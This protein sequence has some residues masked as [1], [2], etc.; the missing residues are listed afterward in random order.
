MATSNCSEAF[1]R[2]AVYQIARLGVPVR[3]VS[4][5]LSVNTRSLCNWRKLVAAPDVN[6]G[7]GYEARNLPLKRKL[8]KV[9]GERDL[10]NRGGSGFDPGDQCP[11]DGNGVCRARVS[12]TYSFIE[13]HREEFGVR[14]MYRVPWVISAASLQ[15]PRNGSKATPRAVLPHRYY[16]SA[17]MRSMRSAS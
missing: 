8:A 6:P 4:R 9:T 13:T 2:D 1:G 11:V 16:S 5:R 7:Q 10:L 12:I 3:E 17:M 15:G 14:A